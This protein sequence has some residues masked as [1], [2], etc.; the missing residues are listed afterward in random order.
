M[1]VSNTSSEGSGKDV[2]KDDDDDD[3]Y[4]FRTVIF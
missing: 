3:Y 4:Y 1:P 2:E